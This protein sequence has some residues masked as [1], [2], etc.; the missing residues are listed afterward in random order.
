[1]KKWTEEE[2]NLS[3]RYIN[4]GFTYDE[5]AELLNRTKKSVRIKLN[6][7]GVYV[8]P[9]IYTIEKKCLH[10]DENFSSLISEDRK[11]CSKSCAAKENNKLYIKRTK[12][13]SKDI[14][15]IEKC[16]IIKKH[17]N[18]CLNCGIEVGNSSKIYCSQ[19]CFQESR[20]KHYKFLIESGDNTLPSRQYKNYLIEKYG[21]KC[22][23]CGWGEKNL[24]SN[25]IP[26]ELEHIDGDSGNNNLSNLKL[27]CPNC[28]SL[29]PTYKGANKGNGR[30]NRKIRYNEGKSY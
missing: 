15:L 5:I 6:K 21:N 20:K 26:I 18:D 2:F 16:K 12:L 14:E 24:N 4:D 3:V 28:H 30:H 27:L 1:M 19:S 13:I 25:T 17:L 29:T 11:Y 8:K 10:C 23:E 22:M 9:K 7:F